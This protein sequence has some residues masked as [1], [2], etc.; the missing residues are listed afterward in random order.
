MIETTQD[1]PKL[2]FDQLQAIDVVEK[3]LANL[4]SEV[5]I[6]TKSL[7]IAKLD[8]DRA[9][10]ENIYQNELLAIVSAQVIEKQTKA[11]AL[12]EEI[13]AK[14]T[15]LSE[16]QSQFVEIT[17][18]KTAQEMELKEKEDKASAKELELTKKEEVLNKVE[19]QLT[20]NIEEFNRKVG[21]LKQ[22][23]ETF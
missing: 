15:Q 16:I 20:L 9:T 23:I 18:K 17:N 8:A 1:N 10:K 4:E 11:T 7:R 3:R 5:N 6:A 14:S 13:I 12:D 21:T 22:V 19:T 2:T